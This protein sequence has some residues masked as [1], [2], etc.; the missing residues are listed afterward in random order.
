MLSHVDGPLAV[1]SSSMLED[2]LHQP[3]AGI[4]TTLMIPNNAAAPATRLRELS[5]AIRL[6]YASTFS[7]NAKSYLKSTGK[8]VEEERMGI[9]IQELIGQRYGQRFYPH[10]AGVAESYNFY[11][12]GPQKAE[13][14]V[15]HIALG[16]GR[17][18]VDGG[19]SLRFN[20]HMPGVLPPHPTTKA[21]LNN[22]QRHFYALDLERP[23]CDLGTDLFTT[24]RS[25]E[26]KDAED[27][28]TLAPVGSVFS[29]DDRRIRDDL[30]L[31]G[32]RVV[33][34]NNILRHKAIPLPETLVKILE[35]AEKGMGGPVEIEFAC[36]MGDWGRRVRRGQPRRKPTLYLLQLRPFAALTQ[37]NE[38]TPLR[39]S[40]EQS[41]CRTTRS[42]GHG[43][44]QSV[45][46]VVYVRCDGWESSANQVIAA[47]V[48]ALNAILGDERRPYLLIG[49]GRWGSSDAWLGIPV[50]WS[51]ISNVRVVVEA[52]PAGYD[53]EP[54]QGTHFFQNITSLRLGYLTLPAGADKDAGLE[55]R[56]HRLGVARRP[57]GGARNGAPAASAL[58]RATHY[59][60]ERSRR[61]RRHRQAGRRR[62]TGRQA[63]CRQFC[64][65]AHGGWGHCGRGHCGRGHCGRGHGGQGHDGRGHDGRGHDGREPR[66]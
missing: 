33:T 16:L 48:E 53:I 12:L 1:R 43:F 22:T 59:R 28:R 13:N 14:G 60:P 7:Q 21:L 42:L 36:D 17:F 63:G 35:I 41:L 11:P 30:S 6:V 27:D 15:V 62:H 5:A 29:A 58:R 23:C 57:E 10:F 52:S 40:A 64:Q 51:Q 44:D 20:P 45:R 49:P 32:P 2:S 65:E 9:I 54:S 8:L 31:K 50:K 46:D 19:R 56:L 66:D 24:V 34:F 61:H 18:V 55:G 3:F 4:Y 39:F 25:Y 37:H 47:E 38:R 26:L